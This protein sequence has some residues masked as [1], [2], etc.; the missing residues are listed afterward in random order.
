MLW[1]Y[2]RQYFSEI[3]PTNYITINLDEKAHIFLELIVQVAKSLYYP[4]C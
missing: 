1:S 3:V 2:R 4:S